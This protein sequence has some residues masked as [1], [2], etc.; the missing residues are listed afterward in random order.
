M[1]AKPLDIL[2]AKTDKRCP[3]CGAITGPGKTRKG[4]VLR[5]DFDLGIEEGKIFGGRCPHC[6]WTF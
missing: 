1:I 4:K 5:G 3:K 2:I 6:L